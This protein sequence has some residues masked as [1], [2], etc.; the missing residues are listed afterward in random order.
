MGCFSSLS[1]DEIAEQDFDEL[2]HEWETEFSQSDYGTL[3]SQEIV[4]DCDK[5]LLVGLKTDDISQQ[6][7]EDGLEELARLVETAGGTVLDTVQ[8]KR[9]RPHPQT[10]VGQGKVE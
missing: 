10:V 8:Q 6:R 5:V 7:F 1:L 2:V 3:S 9:S 4:S